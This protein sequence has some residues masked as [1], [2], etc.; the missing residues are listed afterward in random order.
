VGVEGFEAL[1][2]MYREA[3]PEKC[4]ALEVEWRAVLA[5]AE[6]EPHAQSLRR[7][8]HQLSGSGGAYGYEA[9]GE[10]A[11]EL[12][13]RWVQWLNLPPEKRGDPIELCVEL[14]PLMRTLQESLRAA[15]LP[16]EGEL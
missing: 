6:A 10:M 5:G 4:Q 8:L 7:Q 15:S 14:E 9:M 12:E 16:A 3:L 13:K 1:Q 11:R 2:R